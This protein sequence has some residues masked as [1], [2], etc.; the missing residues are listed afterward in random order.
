MGPPQD[1][2]GVDTAHPDTIR[3]SSQYLSP[4]I[5]LL[6]KTKHLKIHQDASYTWLKCACLR[7]VL[8]FAAHCFE[9][10]PEGATEILTAVP[11]LVTSACDKLCA[12]EKFFGENALSKQAC[13]ATC[14]S[15]ELKS[16]TQVVGDSHQHGFICP[17]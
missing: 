3:V 14:R 5:L 17:N 10:Y 1:L 15:T 11:R 2:W 8:P 13:C 16:F 7:D 6:Q 9:S 4:H 12:E